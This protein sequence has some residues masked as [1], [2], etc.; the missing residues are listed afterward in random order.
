M[1]H[2]WPVRTHCIE[3]PAGLVG[4]VAGQEG[5]ALEVAARRELLEETGYEAGGITLV[6][7][8]HQNSR[9]R[10]GHTLV[11]LDCVPSGEQQLD[12]FEDCEVVVVPLAEF[13]S[14][15]R[16][17]QITTA[18]QAYLGLDSLGLL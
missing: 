9:T 7:T 1:R 11:A 18:E 16:S 14:L 3:L 10:P 5:E 17:G 6:A 2:R 8:L 12:D 4:D 15:L 13:R